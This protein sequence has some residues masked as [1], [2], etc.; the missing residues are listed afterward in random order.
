MAGP[1]KK[2]NK[3]WPMYGNKSVKLFY[4][5]K[6]LNFLCMGWAGF[7]VTTWSKF[8]KVIKRELQKLICFKIVY[9]NKNYT[10]NWKT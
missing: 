1:K 9:I 4:L 3:L 6:V 10:L 7:I 2:K 5:D 8:S